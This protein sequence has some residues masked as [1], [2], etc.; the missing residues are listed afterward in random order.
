MTRDYNPLFCYAG[1]VIN[2]VTESA[3]TTSTMKET[4][5]MRYSVGDD[6]VLF[7]SKLQS[8]PTHYCDTNRLRNTKKLQSLLSA[9]VYTHARTHALRH[10]HTSPCWE[11]LVA[12]WLVEARKWWLPA[13]LTIFT[14]C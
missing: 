4:L 3:R 6:D 2:N 8:R 14:P 12:L 11:Y 5:M 9:I 7:P 1:H 10:T 13:Y